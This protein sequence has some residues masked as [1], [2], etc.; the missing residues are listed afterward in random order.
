MG[1][2]G[3]F[4]GEFARR[5]DI[6]GGEGKVTSIPEIATGQS[7]HRSPLKVMPVE[8][9]ASAERGL[10]PRPSSVVLRSS[11]Q[12]VSFSSAQD[13]FGCT[14]ARG[15]ISL[16]VVG[17]VTPLRYVVR[18]AGGS[19]KEECETGFP[20]SEDKNKNEPISPFERRRGESGSFSGFG[21][22]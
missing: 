22:E 15:E 20:S 14:S 1:M 9:R 21:C 6:G 12:S 2:G 8:R 7:L 19:R 4:L 11:P 16:G 3:R 10:S 17:Q 13:E 5:D 18:R